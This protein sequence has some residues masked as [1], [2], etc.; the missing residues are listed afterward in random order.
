VWELELAFQQ[1]SMLKESDQL[2]RDWGVRPQW[3]ANF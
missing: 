2:Y 1:Y 3:E